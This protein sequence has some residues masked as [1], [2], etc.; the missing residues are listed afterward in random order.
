MRIARALHNDGLVL[1]VRDEHGA[2][3]DGRPVLLARPQVELPTAVLV[4]RLAA[5]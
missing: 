5:A 1:L 3:E 4:R 2:L